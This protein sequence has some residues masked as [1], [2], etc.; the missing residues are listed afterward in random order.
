MENKQKKNQKEEVSVRE[1]FYVAVGTAF[2][3]FLSFTGYLEFLMLAV[4]VIGGAFLIYGKDILAYLD[5]E[6][7]KE[8][9]KTKDTI[10]KIYE[11]IGDAIILPAIMEIVELIKV[12]PTLKVEE[13]YTEKMKMSRQ[14]GDLVFL[15]RIPKKELCEYD[16]DMLYNIIRTQVI[17]QIESG[18]FFLIPEITEK[19]MNIDIIKVQEYP[20]SISIFV[21]LR[22]KPKTPDLRLFE[23]DEF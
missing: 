15:Y 19:L 5:K 14:N 11:W 9:L 1:L 16:A 18:N 3:L 13:I 23:D 12:K 6:K 4:L 21:V 10:T 7:Q 2:F 8:A 20:E 17:R 22:D